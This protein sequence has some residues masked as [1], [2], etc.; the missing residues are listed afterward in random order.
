MKIYYGDGGL[1]TPHLKYSATSV[2]HSFRR[3]LSGVTPD[4][5]IAIGPAILSVVVAIVLATRSGDQ[6]HL[7]GSPTPSQ[8]PS[9]KD[10]WS[11]GDD[12]RTLIMILGFIEGR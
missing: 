7:S 11:E 4:G 9:H 6:N 10:E 8:I 1:P 3:Y 12:W 5:H 2:L